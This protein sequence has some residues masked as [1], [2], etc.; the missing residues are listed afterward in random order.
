MIWT[1]LGVWLLIAFAGAYVAGRVNYAG[2]IAVFALFGSFWPLAL[3]GGLISLPF[4]GMFYL[5]RRFR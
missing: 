5:G 1:W 3:I 2:V 4:I